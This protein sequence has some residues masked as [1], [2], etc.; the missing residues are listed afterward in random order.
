[1]RIAAL[2]LDHA[3]EALERLSA[4]Q[5]VLGAFHRLVVAGSLGRLQ[6]LRG[7]QDSE[8][9]QPPAERPAQ[10]FDLKIWLRGCA[11]ERSR[12]ATSWPRTW[13]GSVRSTL[14]STR[15]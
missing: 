9:S 13:R 14:V 7:E 12:R 11:R 15:S 10:E 2:R 1:V 3:T 4:V 8:V 5:C 6:T